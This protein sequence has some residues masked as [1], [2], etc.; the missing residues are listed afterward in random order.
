MP[1]ALTKSL[2]SL[3]TVVALTILAAAPADAGT[4]ELK[5]A[6]SALAVLKEVQSTPVS[7]VV[8][9]VAAPVVGSI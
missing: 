3:L 6:Q 7:V 9:R 4:K 8:T 1:H 5:R 2:A